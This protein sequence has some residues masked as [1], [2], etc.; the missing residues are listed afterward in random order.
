MIS[1]II[2]T[3]NRAHTILRSINSVLNQ[4]YTDLELLI[5]DDGST[6]NTQKLITQIDDSRVRYIYLGAN[7][8]ASNARNVGVSA[9]SGE[10]I[11]FQDSDDAWKPEKLEKQLLLASEHPEYNLIYSSF[12]NHLSNGN[13][14]N[15]PPKP[16][17]GIMEGELYSSLLLQNVI[18]APTMLIKREAFLQSGGFDTNYK[19]LEDWEFVIRFS[20][21]NLIGFVPDFL[22]DVYIS[23]DGIS[24]HV[25]PYYESRCRMLAE[26]KEDIMKFGLFDAIVMDILTRATDS[27][28]QEQVKKMLMLYL[29]IIPIKNI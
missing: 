18:G 14:I 1:V 12:T 17:Q 8:G 9:A 22:M 28:V 27:G 24:S 29:Q 26:Y 13:I 15:F 2:P 16:Y 3:Y 19:S 21:N 25:A 7:S 4:T 6:D 5:I 23:N 11:A 10:W 20:K